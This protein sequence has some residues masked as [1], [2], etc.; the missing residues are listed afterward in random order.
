M[1]RLGL[2]IPLEGTAL[3]QQQCHLDTIEGGG[4]TDLW[5]AEASGADAFTPL[6]AAAVSHPGF[7]LG[8][9]IASAFTRGPALIAMSAAA[10]ADVAQGDVAVGIGAGSDVIVEKW[11]GLKFQAPYQQVRDVV[12]F[13]RRALTGERIDMVCDSFR[14]D[15]FR[16]ERVPRRQPKLLIAALRPGMLRLAGAVSDGAIVNWLAASDVPR[17]ERCVRSTGSDAEIVARLFV[18]PSE[19][20]AL[21][22]ATARRAIAA[23]LNVPVYAEF[24][25][26]LGR[27]DQL[28]PMWAA[29]QSGDRAAALAAIPEA[30]ID[31]LF[32][33]GSPSDIAARTREYVDAGVTTPVL[34]IMPAK[35][36]PSP[37]P[38]AIASIGRAFTG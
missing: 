5:S 22:R 31:D 17:V 28:E 24:H 15:G 37:S 38:E 1:S 20:V 35:G 34:A 10:L 26:W 13:V 27:G 6:V 32:I 19:D 11:N 2:T 36:Q 29:W 25:R 21:V 8:T 33:Y 3:A 4:F 7:R 23:Y 16:L 30:V 12:S 18:V 9:A 14:I